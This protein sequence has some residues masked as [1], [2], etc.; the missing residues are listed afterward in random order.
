MTERS[1]IEQYVR[2][3][4]NLIDAL[5]A[6]TQGLDSA[7]SNRITTDQNGGNR[8]RL[9]RYACEELTRDWL[10]KRVTSIYPDEATRKWTNI[11]FDSKDK[12][13]LDEKEKKLV[14]DFKAYEDKL[15]TRPKFN[16]GDKYSN[17][18]GG[19]AIIM[20]IDDGRSPDKPVDRDKIR[21]VKE[22]YEFDCLDIRP[23][24]TGNDPSDDPEFYQL[25]VSNESQKKLEALDILSVGYT[26]IHKSRVIRFDGSWLPA[27]LLRTTDGWGDPLIVACLTDLVNYEKVGNSMAS[28]LQDHTVLLHKMKGLRTL[29][30]RSVI[31]QPANE[32][33]A[34]GI[35][36]PMSILSQQF[37]AM[38]L[39]MRMM[40]AISVDSEDDI[41]YLTRNYQGL[42]DMM[43]RFR[44]KLA[45]ATGIPYTRLFG[46]GPNGL[47]AGG[48]GDAEEL[49]WAAMVN[50]YQEVNYR[51]KKLDRLY[52]Y[53]WLAKDG[54]TE[55][56]IPEN[57]SYYFEPLAEPTPLEKEQILQA[58][59]TAQSTYVT[60]LISLITAG[61]ITAE[62]VRN[63][64]FG[65]GEFSY[66]FILD[67][68]TWDKQKKL[69]EQQQKE[70]A[71]Q[72]Q[73][74]ADQQNNYFG[75]GDQ[76]QGQSQQQYQDSTLLDRIYMDASDRFVDI[77]SPFAR[78]WIQEQKRL[79]LPR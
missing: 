60:M 44:D 43:D 53:I 50:N 33:N 49:V 73:A 37:R 23:D 79:L 48:T 78:V 72:Q 61:S 67:Q 21:S 22:I 3:D 62:E 11:T 39:M 5:Y 59:M 76:S 25:I 15:D 10:G 71:A 13:N 70:Q 58:R 12:A 45:A 42:P 55:G 68:K 46:R 52:D 57:W 14:A 56:K 66:D 38:K 51:Y 20:N 47:A 30:Q 28:M 24:W 18:Y 9:T 64:V 41:T 6:A 77:K 31:G 34:Q 74:Q 7:P 8:R 54:P 32:L 16:K 40:G 26:K 17:I 29:L 63:S 75:G 1:N 19:S 65:K 4:G 36:Q 35:P 2:Y 69:A 27:R